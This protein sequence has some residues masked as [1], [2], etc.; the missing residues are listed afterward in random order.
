MRYF[1]STM[2]ATASN[3]LRL[4]VSSLLLASSWL[5][6]CSQESP[7]P[8]TGDSVSQLGSSTD[9]PTAEEAESTSTPSEGQT[10]VAMTEKPAPTES[11]TPEKAAPSKPQVWEKDGISLKT[12]SWE[13]LQ[14]EIQKHQGK[15]VVLDLWSTWCAPCVRELPHLIALQKQFPEQV[16]C[17]SMN[18]N[19]DGLD[20]PAEH[21]EEVLELLVKKEARIL[22]FLSTTEDEQIYETID[23]ASIPVA[24]VYDQQGQLKKRFDNEASEFGEEG[25]TYENHIV[26][27]VADMLKPAPPE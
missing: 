14:T 25:F 10:E 20:P 16:V 5:A 11:P 6:G 19:Y 22:N 18:L 7:G 2:Q 3:G 4:T 24:Y 1:H 17:I 27:F 26:P 15:V 8:G 21:A 23:L 13:E 9:L 12:A